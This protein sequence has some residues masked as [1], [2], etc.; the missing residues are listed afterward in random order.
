MDVVAIWSTLLQ[1]RIDNCMPGMEQRVKPRV[2]L[3]LK[4]VEN[5]DSVHVTAYI[6]PCSM[7]PRGPLF[8]FA[9]FLGEKPS[10]R[11]NC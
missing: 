7:P 2:F 8:K 9:F 6:S 5:S 4:F 10:T 1:L 11:S 3:T